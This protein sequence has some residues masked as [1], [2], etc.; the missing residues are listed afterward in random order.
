MSFPNGY[1]ASLYGISSQVLKTL[2]AKSNERNELKFLRSLTNF[3]NVILEG[4]VPFEFRPILLWCKTKCA[5]KKPDRPINGGNTFHWLSAKYIGIN[6][7]ESRQASYG[8]R[9]VGLGTIRDAQTAS[10]VF[11][12]LIEN[13]QPKE[14]VILKTDFENVFNSMKWQFMPENY[15]RSAKL[16]LR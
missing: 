10:H 12:C 8:S 3:V 7:F 14:N 13:P 11:R 9:Q 2:T 6:V 1:S 4:K 15:V 16:F 5:K